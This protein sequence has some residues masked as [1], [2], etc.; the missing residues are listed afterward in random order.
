MSVCIEKIKELMKSQSWCASE[1]ARRMGVSRSEVTRLL[2]GKRQ[3]GTKIITGLKR[4]FPDVPLESLFYFPSVSPNV[5]TNK[6]DIPQEKQS[7]TCDVPIK[8]PNVPQLACTLN[9]VKG[10]IR[11]LR[12][13]Y[14]TTIRF[15]P[16][17][18]S[19]EHSKIK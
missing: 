11:I 15:P 19:V 1:L 12:G 3:G 7:D 6:T 10:V 13:K 18:V 16:G 8:H 5:N 14:L 9:K 17:K 2:S 4:A